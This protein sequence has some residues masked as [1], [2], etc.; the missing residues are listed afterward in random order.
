[1]LS[2]P[3][4]RDCFPFYIHKDV[5]QVLLFLSKREIHFQYD[6]LKRISLSEQYLGLLRRV[7][8]NSSVS[9]DL[10]N[11]PL[12]QRKILWCIFTRHHDGFIRQYVLET[13]LK[14]PLEYFM[15]PFI[16]QLLGEYV[17]EILQVIECSMHQHNLHLFK[18]FILE[19]PT[20]FQTL[21]RRIISYWNEYY[22]HQYPH[23]EDYIG[24]KALNK[25]NKTLVDHPM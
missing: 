10:I 23:F 15:M 2:S 20:Y 19:N 14:Y 21:K 5:D 18:Q 11:L 6:T 4:L 9:Y 8:I 12:S 24:A 1:M 13:L 25:L 16:F 17:Q 7:Y 22:R 3:L